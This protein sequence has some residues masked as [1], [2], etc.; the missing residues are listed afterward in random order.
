MR[1]KRNAEVVWRMEEGMRELARDRARKGEEYEDLGVV[2]LMVGGTL[3][4]LNLVGAEIWTRIN[5]V[6]T[7]RKIARDVAALFDADP[8]EMEGD[9]EEFLRDLARK[10]WV[11]LE[12]PGAAPG[13]RWKTS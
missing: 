12:T 8:D 2:T 6:N 10:G 5:S 9:V 11:I 4:Q 1:P 7:A 13:P 3:H